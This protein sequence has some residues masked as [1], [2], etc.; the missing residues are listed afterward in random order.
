MWRGVANPEALHGPNGFSP[1]GRRATVA[2]S[3]PCLEGPAQAKPAESLGKA[4]RPVPT[5]PLLPQRS[6]SRSGS[7]NTLASG[8]APAI[9]PS[10]TAGLLWRCR[11]LFFG[12]SLKDES[13]E[14]S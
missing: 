8:F 3:R 4:R 14:A 2:P 7:T 10:L 1:K 5:T 13:H 12:D 6:A 11:V 9:R